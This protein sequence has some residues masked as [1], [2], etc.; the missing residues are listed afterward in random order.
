MPMSTAATARRVRT[1]DRRACRPAWL[2]CGILLPLSVFA[3]LALAIDTGPL[4][5]DLSLLRWAYAVAD[6]RADAFWLLASRL[7]H[8][9]GVVPFDIFLVVLL[10][11]LR[12]WRAAA[13]SAVT[14]GGSG[15]LNVAAK[16]LFARERPA[17]W[18]SIAP[19][20]NF[21]FPS[22]HAMGSMTLAW[23]LVLLAWPTRWR[24][25]VLVAML[26]FVP[27]VGWS[28]VH[29]GVHFPSDI[30]AGWSLATAWCVAAWLLL[31]ADAGPRWRDDARSPLPAR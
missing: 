6:D 26:G 23:V 14:L 30:L 31:G 2:V 20:H 7:G 27:A 3:A 8:G 5:F 21:S 12:H 15:L 11:C 17:L 24:W 10:L 16:Q 19:E 13:F 22:G 9:W 28:R 1:E 29:L 18:E 25:P 4:S